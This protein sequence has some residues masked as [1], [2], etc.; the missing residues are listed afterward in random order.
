MTGKRHHYVPRFLQAGFNS[1]PGERAR[2]AWLYRK[3]EATPLEVTLKHISVEVSFYRYQ[4][5]GVD[6]SADE[7]I[8]RAE[9]QRLAPLV[10]KLRTGNP[11][12]I[13]D[14]AALAELFAHIY[15][16]TKA[17]WEIGRL[18]A[19]LMF[20]RLA[21]FARDPQAIQSVLPR[22]LE[23]QRPIVTRLLASRYPDRDV[24][25]LL[26]EWG[27]QIQGVAPEELSADIGRISDALLGW[28]LRALQ[29]S[30]VQSMQELS[31]NPELAKRFHGCTFRLLEFDGARFVQG[32]TPVVFYRAGGF[33]PMLA[34]DEPF[35]YAFLPLT[36][37]RVVVACVRDI[38]HS[39]EGL[40]DASIACS[41]E[42]FIAAAQ[43]PDLATLATT[44]GRSFPV[45]T[46]ADI[47]KLFAEA[48]ALASTADWLGTEEKALVE[49][50]AH[51]VLWPPQ[52]EGVAPSGG[53]K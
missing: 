42:H 38:P 24:G 30:K 34:K 35:D 12:S 11:T 21:M 16:R 20:E 8:T 17:V 15:A 52:D 23:T 53:E 19:P 25:E 33:T 6:I 1:R 40:R 4:A 22:L 18:Q 2:R 36:P 43:Y 48:V 39:W 31:K 50:L 32:D 41:Y 9:G 14:P 46:D 28:A 27:E 5:S 45:V 51:E 3:G 37:M 10:Q 7:A 13:L 49:R 47:E 26:S 44:I 29:V